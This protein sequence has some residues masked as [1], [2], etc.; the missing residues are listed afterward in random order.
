MEF[1]W[2]DD[3]NLSNIRKHGV[4]FETARQIFVRPTLVS[5]DDRHDYGEVRKI[6][7]GQT[8]AP[9]VIAVVHS[10]RGGNIRL[11]SARPASRN[12]RRT[13]HAK[14]RQGT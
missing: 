4:S 13:Y 10:E 1:E 6:S 8:D 2:D 14:V 5:V 9:S 12:E 7:I 11:I 3:K